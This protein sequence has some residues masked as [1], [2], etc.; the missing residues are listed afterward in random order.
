MILRLILVILWVYVLTV[1]KRGK[2]GFYYF[3]LGSVGTFL[4][5]L[6]VMP[7]VKSYFINAFVWVLGIVGRLTGMY[8]SYAQFGMFF[9]D[10]NDTVMSL[11]VDLECSGL[12]EMMVFVSLLAF[13][14]VYHLWEKLKAG[15]LGLFCI[16]VFNF[17]RIFII[18]A[19]IFHFGTSMYSF[20][21]V[22]VGRIVFYVLTLILYFHV[23]TRGQIV[24]Q[25]VGKFNYE[26]LDDKQ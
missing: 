21:H 1:L 24:K 2:L 14:P 25:K 23:F 9:I 8:E 13:F 10:H 18:I 6:G 20:A 11:Y 15:V 12:I 5:L 7:Y 16:C 26:G 17:I 22:I 19:M 4:I 3:L